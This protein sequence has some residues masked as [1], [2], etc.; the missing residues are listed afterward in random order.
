MKN[1]RR[2]F[3]KLLGLSYF[4]TILLPY[5]FLYSAAKKIINSIDQKLDNELPI[6]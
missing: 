1:F 4:T 3:L 6:E 2:S 5:K